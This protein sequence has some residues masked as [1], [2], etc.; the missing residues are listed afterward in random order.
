MEPLVTLEQVSLA[1]KLDLAEDDERTPDIEWKMKQ[2][3]EIVVNYLKKPDHGWTV[4]TVPG[5]VS[6][7]IILVIRSLLDDVDAPISS[8]V[9][10]LLRR[11]RDPALA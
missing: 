6:A 10:D 3:T 9:C 11:L 1:L 7:S 4:E 5:V 2:A 8:A